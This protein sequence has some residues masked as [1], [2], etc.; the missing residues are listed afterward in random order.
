MSEIPTGKEANCRSRVPLT[1]CKHNSQVPVNGAR[2]LKLIVRCAWAASFYASESE[3]W[4]PSSRR[5]QKLRHADATANTHT[6]PHTYTNTQWRRGNVLEHSNECIRTNEIDVD[7]N[8][9]SRGMPSSFY[10]ETAQFSWRKK[11]GRRTIRH[12]SKSK[13]WMSRSI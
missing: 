2:Q 4:R 11:G 3:L 9:L 6:E 10:K 13:V 1:Q 12:K 5:V 7:G 8:E